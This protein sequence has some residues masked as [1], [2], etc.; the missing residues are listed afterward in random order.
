MALH[1][2]IINMYVSGT[3]DVLIQLAEGIA[4]DRRLKPQRYREVPKDRV[5]DLSNFSKLGTEPGWQDRGERMQTYSS[6]LGGPVADSAGTTPTEGFPTS[7]RNLRMAAKKY[8]ERTPNSPEEILKQ[9]VIATAKDFRNYLQNMGG[10]CLEVDSE[11]LY[12]LFNDVAVKVLRDVKVANAFGKQQP[13]DANWPLV[14]VDAK[15]L[16]L[17]KEIGTQLEGLLEQETKDAIRKFGALQRVAFYG[18]ETVE[19]VL[20]DASWE[21]D[22]KDLLTRA[23]E[24]QVA[25]E[26][27]NS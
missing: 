16:E 3:F 27:Y 2:Q 13:A 22:P 10:T 9:A 8:S 25:I 18:R 19:M 5:R 21:K 17:V 24:W 20:T 1:D 6:H 12:K 15:G 14:R 4:K 26:E 23:W 7:S 11:D